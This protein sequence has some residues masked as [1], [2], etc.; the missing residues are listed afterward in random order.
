MRAWSGDEREL[1][2]PRQSKSVDELELERDT[3]YLQKIGM[4]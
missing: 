4:L 1:A 3:A 2:I